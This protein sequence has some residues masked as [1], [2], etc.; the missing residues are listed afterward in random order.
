VLRSPW[1]AASVLIPSSGYTDL[2]IPSS[3]VSITV[4]SENDSEPD[5]PYEHLDWDG[6]RG[7]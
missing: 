1:L 6:C 5:Q 4:Q 7:V 3:P 2:Y